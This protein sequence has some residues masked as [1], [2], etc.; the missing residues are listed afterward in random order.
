M[1]ESVPDDIAAVSQ[2]ETIYLAEFLNTFD[3]YCEIDSGKIF[4]NPSK[5]TLIILTQ[6]IVLFIK[7]PQPILIKISLNL[8]D[9]K[10][11]KFNLERVGQYLQ[12]Q[13]LQKLSRVGVTSDWSKL[14]DQNDCLKNSNYIYP[15]HKE[16]SL[17]QE[18]NNLRESVDRLFQKPDTLISL[19]LQ[20]VYHLDLC[21]LTNR[22]TFYW[23]HFD[24]E[25]TGA[26]LFT[27]TVNDRY[28]FF[29]EFIPRSETVKFAKFEFSPEAETGESSNVELKQKFPEMKLLHSQFYNEKSI[30]M[31]F[32][33]KKERPTSNC[34]VQL[35]I[36]PLLT[37]LNAAKIQ[38]RI[39]IEPS[40]PVIN[41]RQFIDPNVVRTLDISDGNN[42]AV[43][44]GRKIATIISL[45][46]RKFYHFEMEVDEGDYDDDDDEDGSDNENAADNN[47]SIE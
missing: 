21:D 7:N 8:D 2:Q 24:I 25:D 4:F 20:L 22:T 9:R 15:H 46:R 19:N 12:N 38:K 28:I 5:S 43:S 31:L 42:L 37:R 26:T 40:I 3:D 30:S 36:E 47:V 45:S 10:K 23:H 11:R 18:H 33:C 35:P 32:S 44:G 14:L 29:K 13:K 16:M 34:F 1:E 17:V 41:L 27:Y 39:V 6:Y